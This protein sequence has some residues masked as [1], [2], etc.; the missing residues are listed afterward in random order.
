M[1]NNKKYSASREF[2]EHDLNTIKKYLREDKSPKEMYQYLANKGDRYALFAGVSGSEE[3]FWGRSTLYFSSNRGL[4]LNREFLDDIYEQIDFNLAN[5][6]I[7]LLENK[8]NKSG[9]KSVELTDL[10]Y[11]ELVEINRKACYVSWF[12]IDDWYLNGIFE[13]LSLSERQGFWSHRLNSST[14]FK[15]QVNHHY[16]TFEMMLKKH[17]SS[18][19]NKNEITKKWLSNNF[20]ATEY[21]GLTGNKL[22]GY[23]DIIAAD[24]ELKDLINKIDKSIKTEEEDLG[25]VISWTFHYVDPENLLTQD[26]ALLMKNENILFWESKEEKLKFLMNDVR[27][28]IHNRRKKR[29]ALFDINEHSQF[30]LHIKDV[31]SVCKKVEE[32][33]A[34]HILYDYLEAN[35]EMYGVI[36]NGLVR[37]DSYAGKMAT[38]YLVERA[39]QY[40]IKLDHKDLK[41]I[42]V[43]VALETGQK[44]LDKFGDEKTTVL[45]KKFTIRDI[46]DIHDNAFTSLNLP[47]D[48]WTLSIPLEIISPE[49]HNQIYSEM[50]LNSGSNQNE[51]EFG[52]YLMDE[53]MTEI[54]KNPSKEKFNLFVEWAN[55]V[56]TA[57]NIK[58][59]GSV[60]GEYL[61]ERGTTVAEYVTTKVREL[62]ELIPISDLDIYGGANLSSDKKAPVIS[63]GIMPASHPLENMPSMK[64]LHNPSNPLQSTELNFSGHD[65][66]S[67]FLEGRIQSNHHLENMPSMRNLSNSSNM[68]HSTEFNFSG[69]DVSSSFLEGR[70]QSNHHLENM[71]GN[72]SENMSSMEPFD[73]TS[74]NYFSDRTA[75]N[76]PSRFSGYSSNSF[77]S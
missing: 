8:L 4:W 1:L 62:N 14:E 23:F 6:Y 40:N 59:T 34:P 38:N 39:K 15:E 16:K 26:A 42:Q 66:S 54:I 36:P 28:N 37:G 31:Q 12:S 43:K 52:L 21:R 33:R 56:S 32:D 20:Y 63:G 69:Y 41:R 7:I 75:S 22:K 58:E 73:S 65:V 49:K 51:V 55:T 44:L 47:K 72:L 27:E 29:S 25:E 64:N 13:S 3:G 30:E 2:T 60:F 19:E 9:G 57:D 10:S 74:N 24:P 45:R 50:L 67:S 53:M 61:A 48:A 46:E 70:I 35:G 5:E 68:S 17:I 76:I 77:F 11:E 18:T 71:L